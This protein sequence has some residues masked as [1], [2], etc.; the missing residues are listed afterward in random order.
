MSEK[1]NA[2][3]VN[4]RVLIIAAAVF[5]AV[6]SVILISNAI[7]EAKINKIAQSED[8][9]NLEGLSY[10]EAKE[11]LLS[12]D[13]GESILTDK[14]KKVDEKLAGLK[15]DYTGAYDATVILDE[16][17]WE[18]QLYRF[19]KDI[20]K[21]A[22]LHVHA[23]AM[24]TSWDYMEFLKSYDDIYVNTE[25]DFTKSTAGQDPLFQK[26][27]EGEIPESYVNLNQGIISGTVDEEYLRSR[28]LLQN[29]PDSQGSWEYYNN[30]DDFCYENSDYECKKNMYRRAFEAYCDN[31]VMYVEPRLNLKAQKEKTVSR[32]N[33]LL[34]A[35]SET[36]LEH[37]EFKVRVI[38]SYNKGL[39]SDLED[40]KARLVSA[41]ELSKEVMDTSDTD[42]PSPFIVGIDLINEEDT[43]IDL[44]QYYDIIHAVTEINPELKITLHAG[45]SLKV[46]N[47][48]VIDAYL[49][50][51][52]RIGHALCLSRLP[53]LADRFAEEKITVELCPVSN[54]VFGYVPDLRSHPGIEFMRNGIPVVIGSDDPLEMCHEVMT[55]DFY[56]AILSWDLTLSDVKKICQNS[57]DY[58]FLNEKDKKELKENWSKKWD[59]FI[60]KYSS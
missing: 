49:T 50:G 29:K 44:D 43:S 9:T 38:A 20:P 3:T 36:K 59:E 27:E 10:D 22:D 14:E 30:I 28:F 8:F 41:A 32:L 5:I 18:T 33:A 51:A 39:S 2:K 16:K 17:I 35:Y 53:Q 37:P 25:F 31:G 56:L 7:A 42:N 11:V 26:F 24:T 13:C 23:G 4:K 47:D 40:T 54:N 6:C 15:A 52:D 55:D 60:E 19:C 57:I 45:E 1:D 58:S 21:G 12:G 34:D 48:N 46:D